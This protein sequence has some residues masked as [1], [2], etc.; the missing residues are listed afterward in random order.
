MAD[1]VAELRAQLDALRSE[2][3]ELVRQG[4]PS[5]A[6]GANQHH[7]RLNDLDSQVE[8]YEQ[9]V[10]IAEGQATLDLVAEPPPPPTDAENLAG[11]R[12]SLDERRAERATLLARPTPSDPQSARHDHEEVEELDRDIESIERKIDELDPPPKPKKGCAPVP[13][14]IVLIVVALIVAGVILLGGDDDEDEVSSD[15]TTSTTTTAPPSDGFSKPD[16]SELPDDAILFSGTSGGPIGFIAQDGQS[17]FMSVEADGAVVGNAAAES[18]ETIW[19]QDG[20]ITSFGARLSVTNP[21]GR[22]GIN[23]FYLDTFEYGP[24]VSIETN[25]T[26]AE[27]QWTPE[28]DGTVHAGRPV[29]IIVGEQGHPEAT[30][31][32]QIEWWFVFLPD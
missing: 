11:L 17:R 8:Q 23:F 22:Y 12:R 3:A 13:A 16:E 29:A 20:Q 6:F 1:R 32:Y 24:G 4:P 27:F 15:V 14:A 7:E 18:V 9:L 10:E 19:D 5:D 25:Q 2:R 31:D 28:R 30:G 26:S 21:G